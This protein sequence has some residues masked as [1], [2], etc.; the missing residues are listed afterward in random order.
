MR[1]VLT[2]HSIDS[3]G[4]AI[5]ISEGD[6]RRHVTWL[7]SG[8]VR[9]VPLDAIATL[10]GDDD[11]VALTFD[12]A[13]QNF[14]TIAAPL[15]EEHSLPATLF[16]VTELAGGTNAWQLRQGPATIPVMPLLDWSGIAVV[17]QRGITIGSHGRTH[18][19]LTSLDADDLSDELHGSALDL[20]REL[21]MTPTT[22]CYPYGDASARERDEAAHV[23]RMAV[24]ADL[25]ALDNSDDIYMLPRLDA[26]YLRQ[27]RRLERF[28]TPAFARYLRLRE[29]GRRLR[30]S[31]ERL[32]GRESA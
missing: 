15:L 24:T 25:R 3:S 27:E 14:G 30:K 23:Y 13:F 21:G 1:A 11:A 7:A 12:D 6:F 28:G 4:S 18:R 31:M 22:F 17:A 2:Y 5:S 9:V 10:E 20:K 32:I 8:R 19:P 29:H 26:Y 16:V